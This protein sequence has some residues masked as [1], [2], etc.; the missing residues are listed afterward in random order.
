MLVTILG[1]LD[2]ITP[3]LSIGTELGSLDGSF[4]CYNY[5]NL[6]GLLLVDSLVY[7]DDKALGS[8]EVI[9]LGST[10]G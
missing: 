4:D 3:G 2:R 5:G 10:G 9:R 1:N 6:E 7:T 8:D